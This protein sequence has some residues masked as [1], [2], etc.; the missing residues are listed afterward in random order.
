MGFLN[1]DAKAKYNQVL[2][3]VLKA[4]R[5]L[6]VDTWLSSG[7]P[8]TLVGGTIRELADLIEKA[9]G[10]AEIDSAANQRYL[11]Q[12]ALGG[13]TANLMQPVYAKVFKGLSEAKLDEVLQSFAFKN[14][15]PRQDILKVLKKYWV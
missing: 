13:Y 14:C 4:K 10:D 6:G 3:P 5:E 9:I 1:V 8:S 15:H 7:L 11:A 2:A 12:T